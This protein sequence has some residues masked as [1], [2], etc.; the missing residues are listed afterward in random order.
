MQPR[1]CIEDPI[2]QSTNRQMRGVVMHLHTFLCFC[3]PCLRKAGA[4]HYRIAKRKTYA[5]FLEMIP[6]QRQQTRNCRH[7]AEQKIRRP[8]HSRHFVSFHGIRQYGNESH[9]LQSTKNAIYSQL[10]YTDAIKGRSET[11]KIVKTVQSNAKT[12]Q[13]QQYVRKSII[14]IAT[15]PAMNE[16]KRSRCIVQNLSLTRHCSFLV[17]TALLLLVRFTDLLIIDFVAAGA[18][19]VFPACIA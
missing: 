18:T 1:C 14:R 8:L 19:L 16:N 12:T 11:H 17:W 10:S 6:Q 9:G 13:F 4:K 5:K 15:P 3:F 7:S 2:H